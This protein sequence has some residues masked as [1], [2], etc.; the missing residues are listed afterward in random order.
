[1]RN[2]VDDVLSEKNSFKVGGVKVSQQGM[3]TTSAVMREEDTEV[4]DRDERTRHMERQSTDQRWMTG[5][6]DHLIIHSEI[7]PID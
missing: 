3:G 4:Y 2:T 1:M 5:L 7:S 6:T